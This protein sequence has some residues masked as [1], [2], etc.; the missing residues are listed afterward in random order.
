[1]YGLDTIFIQQINGGFKP[2]TVSLE[3]VCYVPNSSHH[4]LLVSS[5]THYGYHCKII[6]LRSWIWNKRGCIVIQATALS[7]A[8]N[9]HWFQLEMITPMTDIVA[10]LVNDHSYHIW[11]QC[12]S[13]TSQ[14]TLSH[15][16][17]HLSGVSSFILPTDLAPCKGCQIEKMLDYA[18]PAFG[19]Q[20]SCP[21]TLVYTDLVGPMPTESHSYARYI[22]TFIND[23]IGYAL[24]FFLW[25]KSDCLSNFYNMVF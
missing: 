16:S 4:L 10:S 20:A 2:P 23:C 3:E 8:N 18:F 6:N 11:H 25:T 22:L 9:L 17:T 5:L 13:H 14:N 12:F 21:L 1:M 24:L 7:P 15:V 19:K